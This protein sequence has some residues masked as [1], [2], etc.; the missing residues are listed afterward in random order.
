MEWFDPL[1]TNPEQVTIDRFAPNYPNIIWGKAW[2][3]E[4]GLAYTEVPVEPDVVEHGWEFWMP[5]IQRR[6]RDRYS[7][8]YGSTL[9]PQVQDPTTTSYLTIIGE[10]E[11]IPTYRGPNGVRPSYAGESGLNTE[12]E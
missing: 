11:I 1:F 8:M 9:V 6:Y 7:R 3:P 5:Q 10:S 4:G 12:G 2:R